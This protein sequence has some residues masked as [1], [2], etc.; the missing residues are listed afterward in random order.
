MAYLQFLLPTFAFCVQVDECESCLQ[1]ESHL[2]GLAQCE[3]TQLR[4]EAANERAQQEA[5]DEHAAALEV[6]CLRA[7]DEVQRIASVQL[8]TQQ[9][10]QIWAQAEQARVQERLE[11]E[12][13]QRRDDRA[14]AALTTQ[15]MISAQ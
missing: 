8:W 7:E 2:L 15:V 5:L 13:S 12:I 6:A 14:I 3:A 4:R 10:M 9:E 1:T 11:L